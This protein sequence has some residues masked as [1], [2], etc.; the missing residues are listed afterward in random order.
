MVAFVFFN[1]Q[2]NLQE[3]GYQIASDLVWWYVCDWIY[4][5]RKTLDPK[6][7]QVTQQLL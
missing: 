6:K 3:F 4:R 5:H 7:F 2:I 1:V